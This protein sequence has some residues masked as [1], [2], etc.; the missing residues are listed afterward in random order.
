MNKHI[1]IEQVM[2][3]LREFGHS[4]TRLEISW[5]KSDNRVWGINVSPGDLNILVFY[6]KNRHDLNDH[7]FDILSPK[8]NYFGVRVND[9]YDAID[10]LVAGGTFSNE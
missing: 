6:Y 8:R 1:S 9:L 10:Q 5:N 4:S 7:G 2:A 3:Q